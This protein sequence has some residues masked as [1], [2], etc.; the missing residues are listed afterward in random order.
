MYILIFFFYYS[1][2]F[3]SVLFYS[4]H[5]VGSVSLENPNTPP[6]SLQKEPTLMTT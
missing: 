4:I 3:Y 5:P 1:I 2:L 6:Q